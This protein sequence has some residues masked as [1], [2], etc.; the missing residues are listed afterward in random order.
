MTEGTVD[1]ALVR[2]PYCDLEQPSLALGLL[3]AGCEELGLS[4]RVVAAHLQF[5][6]EI[7]P[8]IHEL[9]FASYS[10]TLVGEWTFSHALFPG[11]EPED[12]NYLRKV[13]DIFVLDSSPEW[14]YLHERFPYLDYMAL[15]R[16]IRRRTPEFVERTVERVLQLQPRIV[17]CSSMFQQHCA[18][19]ALLRG[20][21][22]RRP[23]IIT[24]LGGANCEGEMGRA[25]F[26]QFPFV[27]FVVSGEADAFFAPMCQTLLR[28]GLD[29]VV[30]QLP[31]GVWGPHHRRDPSA[32]RESAAGEV[33]GAPIVRLDD[34]NLSPIPNYDD[35]FAALQETRV[36]GD[37]VRP[38]LPFQTA[39][40]CWWGEK[41]HCSFCGI[42]RT[43]MKFRAKTPDNVIEQMVALRDRYQV[44]VF[45]GTEY[46]FDYRFFESLL[47]R[48][49]E[50]GCLYRF[51]VKANLKPEQ[52]QAL[53][54]SG[55]LEVQPGIESLHDGIL[56]LLKK[57][58]TLLQ[59][60]LLLKR[61]RQI[62]LSIYW[63]LLHT[64]PGDR[65]EWY[66]EIADLL[67]LIHHLMPPSGFGQIHYDRFSPYWR[68]PER[69]GLTL[70][71]AFGYE[72][73]YPFPP[74]VIEDLAY[75]F[76]TPQQRVAFLRYSPKTNPQIFRLTEAVARWKRVF[77]ADPRPR[78]MTTDLG[79]SILFEDTREIA[80]EQRFEIGGLERRVY[81]AAENG[82]M[83]DALVRKLEAECANGN[84]EADVR[85]AVRRLQDRGVLLEAS[86]R[87]V[88]LGIP[89][90]ER[91]MAIERVDRP[92][93]ELSP[94]HARLQADFRLDQERPSI[95]LSCLSLPQDEPVSKWMARL[96]RSSQ[97]AARTTERVAHP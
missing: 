75:F 10:T 58:T 32:L 5:A 48:L 93:I 54:D 80:S 89:G 2:M 65:D 35:F 88:G 37:Y 82:I 38:A 13:I 14:L 85:A 33:D 42:S 25:T 34:M 43:A 73:A 8:A 71:P 91:P 51:D 20:I 1:I 28:S 49:K 79:D 76:E 67:P 72:Y 31:P 74:E 9:V 17:G 55:T 56:A 47:P 45:Q 78:L 84:T 22:Q 36:Y 52:L 44:A 62:G 59:N 97:R 4:N 16:E 70:R 94:I 30:P 27:D 46:I 7:G 68:E 40:G 81:A 87:L 23:D 61:G 63:N 95:A 83:L 96:E 86:G 41:S 64:V 21:K 90:P 60:L 18:S 53:V 24:M 19:L 92:L 15:L 77:I 66:G 3:K 11:F 57:G 26:E 6:E 12:E 29:A 69:H 39:R 50:L